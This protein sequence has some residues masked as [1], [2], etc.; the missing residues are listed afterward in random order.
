M[1][2]V[3]VLSTTPPSA[4]MRVFSGVQ[5]TAN[6]HIGNYLGAMKRFVE[7]QHQAQSL[8]CVVDLH[9]I[10]V[11]Q[12]PHALVRQTREVAA[13]YLACGIDPEKAIIFVQSTVSAHAELAWIFNWSA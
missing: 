5:P 12:D 11:P 1:T 4:P 9:A 13:A 6:I 2:E 7:L 8:F 3:N 10:T